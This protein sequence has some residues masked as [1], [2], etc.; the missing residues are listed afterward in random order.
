MEVEIAPT[1]AN[2]KNLLIFLFRVPP[3][4]ISFKAARIGER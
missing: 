4:D 1:P 2:F 3:E